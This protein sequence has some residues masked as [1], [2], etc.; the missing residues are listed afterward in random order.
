M[1]EVL[2]QFCH[3]QFSGVI[4]NNENRCA[5][6]AKFWK[7]DFDTIKLIILI[8]IDID[9]QESKWHND[10]QYFGLYHWIVDEK[11]IIDEIFSSGR[12]N[13]YKNLSDQTATFH[14]F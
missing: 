3:P 10:F 6:R 2:I 12:V 4:Q 13:L 14:E 7:F 5:I 1:R 11:Y 8:I 9:K